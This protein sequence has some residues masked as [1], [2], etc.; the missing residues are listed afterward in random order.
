MVFLLGLSFSFLN[1]TPWQ[2]AQ[3]FSVST[4]PVSAVWVHF[5]S[6]A[7]SSKPIKSELNYITN[8]MFVAPVSWRYLSLLQFSS[9]HFPAEYALA[10]EIFAPPAIKLTKNYRPL[11]NPN[12]SWVL[13]KNSVPSRLNAWKETNIIYRQIQQA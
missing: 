3:S 8:A 13:S 4:H 12:L 9:E 6:H 2:Q 5:G 11:L 7:Q 10:F 1:A